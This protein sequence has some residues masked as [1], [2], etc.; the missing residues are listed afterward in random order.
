MLLVTIDEIVLNLPNGTD[1]SIVAGTAGGGFS[2]CIVPDLPVLINIA[3]KP[4]FSLFKAYTNSTV[5]AW[6]FGQD[7]RDGPTIRIPNNQLV[8]PDRYV[9]STDGRIVANYS[10]SN[11]AIYPLQASDATKLSMLGRQFLSSAYVMVNQDKGEFTMWSASPTSVEDLVA[12]DSAGNEA[13]G[14][15]SDSA[16]SSSPLAPPP[17]STSPSP[18]PPPPQA[19]SKAGLVPGAIA[20]IAVGAAVAVALILVGTLIWR[21][22]RRRRRRKRN[23]TGTAEPAAYYFGGAPPVAAGIQ[24][25]PPPYF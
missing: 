17:R 5:Q 14:F 21:R 22:R 23:T 8:L 18:S 24:S 19:E 11:L 1:F 6:T 12:I 9:D 13:T 16:A 3:L 10:R 2:A 7:V 20:G 25:N 15:C 4:Y